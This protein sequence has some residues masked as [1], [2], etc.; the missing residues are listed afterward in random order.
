MLSSRAVTSDRGT[1]I[2][3][4]RC[5]RVCKRILRGQKKEEG[6]AR[7]RDRKSY[8]EAKDGTREVDKKG[9]ELVTLSRRHRGA[10]CRFL[11]LQN[12]FFLSF[13]FRLSSS[14]RKDHVCICD[15]I[16]NQ[17]RQHSVLLSLF[18]FFFFRSFERTDFFFFL[19]SRII[20][21][22]ARMMATPD[23]FVFG[24]SFS[25]PPLLFYRNKKR[26]IPRQLALRIIF[27][28]FHG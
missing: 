5:K 26:R 23:S 8:V 14:D 21:P 16:I 19:S 3:N 25:S 18:S 13:A 10:I 4:Y 11:R 12:C 7:S 1:V 28:L 27:Q 22:L 9:V 6:R 17:S 15:E 24:G 20:S 2:P